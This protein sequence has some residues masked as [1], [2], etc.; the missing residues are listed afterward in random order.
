[1][2]L[3]TEVT[4]ITL[5]HREVEVT[6]TN[7][8][9]EVCRWLEEQKELTEFGVDVEWR[10]NFSKGEDNPVALLQIGAEEKCIVIQL[11][12]ID[13]VPE[14]SDELAPISLSMTVS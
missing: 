14:V 9:E 3:T 13:Y 5:H 2:T 11:L 12:Y 1:M 4:N 7:S 8:G 10:P 6:V